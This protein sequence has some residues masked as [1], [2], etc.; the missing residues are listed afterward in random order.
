MDKVVFIT[1]AGNGIGR[2]L[3]IEMAGKGASIIITDLHINYANE[4]KDIILR[5]FQETSISTYALDVRDENQFE[6]VFYKAIEEYTKID[7]MINNAGHSV[8]GPIE[9]LD[10]SHWHSVMGVNFF[11]LVKGSTLALRQMIVQGEGHIVN[12]ASAAGLAF[13]MP[14]G[15]TY[16]ASKAAAIR[17][18]KG[19]EFEASTYGIKTT[20]ICP[21]FIQTGFA[22]RLE[23]LEADEKMES[24]VREGIHKGMPLNKAIDKMISG[25]AQQKQ[26]M[27]FPFQARLFLFIERYLPWLNKRMMIKSLKE[28]RS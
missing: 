17:F 4:T 28:L 24:E 2:A 7:I 14:F 8:V 23:F 13:Y 16:V 19:L 12:I 5:Q 26:F 20:T 22:D 18:S 27:I 11:G 25:I 10:L 21:A 3:S 9:K 6:E 15:S 1:G